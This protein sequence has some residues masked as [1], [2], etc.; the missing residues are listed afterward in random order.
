[1]VDVSV[2]VPT[3]NEK[4]N[5]SQLV[6]EIIRY[7]DHTDYE[8]V[9]VDDNSPDGT[10]QVANKLAK[11]NKRIKSIVRKNEK[12]LA[13]AIKRG[14]DE[15]KGEIIVILDTD[16]SHPPKDIARLVREIKGQ[17][18]ILCSRYVK[19]GGMKYH[20][21]RY[22]LSAILNLAIQGILNSKIKD[23]TNGFFAIRRSTLYKLDMDYIFTGYGDFFFKL[24]YLMKKL[25]GAKI[26][27]IPF[28]YEPRRYGKSKTDVFDVGMSYLLQA[29]KVRLKKG[30][31]ATFIEF[32]LTNIRKYFIFIFGGF[33]GA[34]IG[35]LITFLM[36]QF[37]GFYYLVSFTIGEI[38]TFIFNFTYHKNVTFKNSKKPFWT[39]LKFIGSYLLIYVLNVIFIYLMTEKLGFYY[40]VS[41]VTVTLVLSVL[42]FILNRLFVFKQK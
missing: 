14:I 39:F 6:E 4:G 41:I 17:D 37:A 9:I 34:L 38:G 16:F 25:K 22:F 8:V 20:K 21:H 19:G 11:E 3:Y 33:L 28:V 7:I 42:N 31:L 5:L 40:M 29:F 26:K 32:I 36:T 1:M 35:W 15:S 2:I 23:L 12:G 24:A 30:R 13:T 27:E 10:W 18:M